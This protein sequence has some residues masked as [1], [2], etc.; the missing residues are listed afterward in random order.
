MSRL[1]IEQ[2]SCLEV[3]AGAGIRYME[4][5]FDPMPSG[6]RKRMRESL[7]NLCPAC[8]EIGARFFADGDGR[9]A[10]R[11]EM[12]ESDYLR[13]IREMEFKLKCEAA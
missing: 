1:I 8:V 10:W 5:Y 12:M 3:E 13:A 11:N 7:W 6:A 2:V 9:Y 4:P